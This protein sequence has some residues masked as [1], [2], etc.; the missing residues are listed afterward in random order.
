MVIAGESMFNDGSAIVL[1]NLMLS[2]YS[3]ENDIPNSFMEHAYDNF[4]DVALYAIKSVFGGMIFG[5]VGGFLSVMLLEVFD[6]KLHENNALLQL[7]TTISMAYLVFYVAEGI[8]GT[9]GVIATVSLGMVFSEFSRGLIVSHEVLESSWE[10][11]EFVGNTLIFSVAGSICGRLPV[12]SHLLKFVSRWDL[13]WISVS[14]IFSFL[15]RMAMLVVVYPLMRFCKRNE[16]KRPGTSYSDV[17]DLVVEGWGGLRGAVGL[18]LAILVRNQNVGT[19]EEKNGTLLLIHVAGVSALT[20]LVNA[21]SATPLLKLLGLTKISENHSL[22][23]NNVHRKILRD[24]RA[25][26]NHLI[27]GHNEDW[28]VSNLTDVIRTAIKKKEV[29][30]LCSILREA[31]ELAEKEEGV[32]GDSTLRPIKSSVHS[33]TADLWEKRELFMKLV[34]AEYNEMVDHRAIILPPER[35]NATRMLLNSTLF[36]MDDLSNQGDWEYLKTCMET[37]RS[38]IAFTKTQDFI[39]KLFGKKHASKKLVYLYKKRQDVYAMLLAFEKAHYEAEEQL[40]SIFGSSDID[41]AK[42]VEESREACGAARQMRK[43][44]DKRLRRRVSIEHLAARILLYERVKVERL[45][46]G[47]VLLGRDEQQLLGENEKDFARLKKKNDALA[48][49]LAQDATFR[50]LNLKADERSSTIYIAGANSLIH[51]DQQENEGDKEEYEGKRSR[52]VEA[53]DGNPRI[54][55]VNLSAMLLSGKKANGSSKEVLMRRSLIKENTFTGEHFSVEDPEMEENAR[56]LIQ[57]IIKG[58]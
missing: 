14:W 17:K 41:T 2:L 47:G 38:M 22:A 15:T 21:T 26:S 6:S 30:Q 54:G 7:T 39:S 56:E 23:V 32:K 36:A 48:K 10:T 5:V 9:S 58:G 27:S 18:A 43:K 40:I 13:F 55:T 29:A 8:A 24:V 42:V 12:D 35:H 52:D 33:S 46:E 25:F 53:G 1:F 31:E 57:E 4:G 19:T 11:F 34:R 16:W 49:E 20:L 28:E 3:K 45:I 50:N 37:S 44:M 51:P